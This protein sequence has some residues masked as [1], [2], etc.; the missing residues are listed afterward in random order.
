[1]AVARRLRRAS[2]IDEPFDGG[3]VTRGGRASCSL[4]SRS[5]IA[6]GATYAPASNP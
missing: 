6:A 1:M 2:V 3:F 4:L 5:A